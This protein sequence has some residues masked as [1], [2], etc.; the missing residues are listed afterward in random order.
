MFYHGIF[1][2]PHV[3]NKALKT[4]VLF[5]TALTNLGYET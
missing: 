4:A 1:L 3:V 2:A 5:S